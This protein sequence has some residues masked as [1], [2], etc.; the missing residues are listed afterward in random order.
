M[1]VEC[2]NWWDWAEGKY[3]ANVGYEACPDWVVDAMNAEGATGGACAAWTRDGVPGCIKLYDVETDKCEWETYEHSGDLDA[4]RAKCAARS[5]CYAIQYE[6]SGTSWCDGCTGSTDAVGA[7]LSLW[8]DT[9]G[10]VHV[11]SRG[12]FATGS[13]ANDFPAVCPVWYDEAA[14]QYPFYYQDDP[15][16][17]DL[18]DDL[19]AFRA[20]FTSDSG[21]S[22]FVGLDALAAMNIEGEVEICAVVTPLC[23]ASCVKP[24]LSAGVE[25]PGADGYALTDNQKIVALVSGVCG[26][27]QQGEFF[28][29]N[30]EIFYGG[31]FR[32]ADGNDVLP[33]Q[34]WAGPQ[35]SGGMGV[36]HT[37]TGSAA[38]HVWGWGL[39]L[40]NNKGLVEIGYDSGG[41][42]PSVGAPAGSGG[43]SFT[44]HASTVFARV[45]KS[46]GSGGYRDEHGCIPS[47]GYTWCAS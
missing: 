5:D 13:P 16:A 6:S 20:G 41:P 38:W 21:T 28:F 36:Y 30:P 33:G 23:A 7:D 8:A 46:S 3:W 29:S 10:G 39:S 24:A 4:C 11:E 40:D 32:D 26:T 2:E 1:C 45:Q 42:T 22:Y 19:G 43:E 35:S 17:D 44:G 27:S 18:P 12:C 9:S 47:A 25:C 14:Y 15:G 31:G 34:G 37:Q